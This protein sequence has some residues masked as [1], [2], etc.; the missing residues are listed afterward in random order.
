VGVVAS[1]QVETTLLVLKLAFL[2]LLYLFIWRIVRSAARDLRLPQES[3][4]LAPQQAAAAGL[5]PQPTAQPLGRLVV[6]VSPALQEG[7]VF[8][9]D[10]HPLTVGRG[11]NNDVS[12]SSD[13]YA[14]GRH[15]RFEP[16]R[17][18]VWI[19]DIGSTN[20]TFVNGIRLTRERKLTPGDVV[21]IGETD[22]RFEP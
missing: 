4:I 8:T 14:S 2:V 10:S 9:L 18:G 7:D 19:E 13:E 3:M 11:N 16:R 1:A 15:A 17:D 20:G 21:R 6:L 5:I 22:L 12:I